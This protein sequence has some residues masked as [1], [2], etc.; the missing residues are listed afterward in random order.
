[1][2]ISLK[3]S[4]TIIVVGVL[5]LI[6]P[7][8]VT[9]FWA[10]QIGANALILGMIALTI[11][12]LAGYGGMISLAQVTVAGVAGYSIAYFGINNVGVGILLPW[13][14][15]V[16]IALTFGTFAGFLIGL[17][18]V[19]TRG[20]Y[21]LMITLALS[22]VFFYFARQNYTLF[23]G[24]T[25]F[26]GVTAPVVGGIDLRGPVVF[27][28]LCLVV[29]GLSY[30]FVRYIERSPFGLA[31]QGIRDNERRMRALGYWVGFHRVAAFT[32]M[33]LMASFA[34]ILGVWYNNRISA[35]SVGFAQTFDL[36]IIAVIGGIMHPI[37]AFLGAIVFVLVENFAIDFID[38]ERFNTLIGLVFLLIVF[39]SPD[40]LVGLWSKAKDQWVRNWLG[41]RTPGSTV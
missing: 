14:V 34:G 10:V 19:R 24:F 3:F 40:G 13:P 29:A 23:N 31:L 28:Y 11:V 39:F 26:N 25:G 27:Y 21:M 35:G 6:Y 1:M 18:S 8:V 16:L 12:F 22:V 2:T 20:I 15:G 41:R 7:L 32:L 30:G 36:I 33:G 37:G 38:R 5:L 4:P 9:P 17:I